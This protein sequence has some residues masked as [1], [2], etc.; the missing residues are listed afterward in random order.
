[1][2]A[3]RGVLAGVYAY[4][5]ARISQKKYMHNEKIPLPIRVSLSIQPVLVTP[6]MLPVYL[7]EDSGFILPK[8]NDLTIKVEEQKYNQ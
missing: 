3:L 8:C 2:Y 5:T 6:F 1:M 4:G 7:A